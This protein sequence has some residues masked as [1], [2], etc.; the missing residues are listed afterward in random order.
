MKTFFYML[1][2]AIAVMACSKSDPSAYAKDDAHV[3]KYDET[4]TRYDNIQP[5]SDAAAYELSLGKW[6]GDTIKYAIVGLDSFQKIIIHNAANIWSEHI[7]KRMIYVLDTSK[8]D[9]KICKR[10]LGGLGG[11]LG[12]SWYPPI[13]E[14][15]IYPVPIELD[16]WDVATVEGRTAFD[17][18]QLLCMR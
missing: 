4:A 14:Y 1:M 15:S 17:F 2:L 11:R 7:N 13:S 16:K 12:Q 3:M 5:A 10:D 6:E 18:F 8:C 9:I